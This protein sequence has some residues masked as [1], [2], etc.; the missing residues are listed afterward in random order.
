MGK[1]DV[2]VGDSTVATAVQK[3]ESVKTALTTRASKSLDGILLAVVCALEVMLVFVSVSF[4]RTF[5]ILDAVYAFSESAVT[6]VVFY[7]FIQPGKNGRIGMQSFQNA[8]NEWKTLCNHLRDN[9]LL[10][11]FRT[12]CETCTKEERQKIKDAQIERLENLYVT[13]EEYEGTEE[14][15]GYCQMTKKELKKLRKAKKISKAAYKQIL[16]CQKPVETPPYNPNLILD[17]SDDKNVRRGLKTGDHYEAI[18]IALKPLTCFIVTV[19]TKIL[20]ITQNDVQD[21]FTVVVSVFFTIFCIC[22]SAFLGYRF[23]WNCIT[24]EQGYIEARSGFIRQFKENAKS[25][26]E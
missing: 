19:I 2:K 12:H 13:R 15:K 16:V 9:N 26:S 1:Y 6:I 18:G 11:L 17:G 24:R 5:S 21:W 10:R 3:V 8:Y 14:Q 22:L 20:Q 7:M 23:G 4:T 25:P